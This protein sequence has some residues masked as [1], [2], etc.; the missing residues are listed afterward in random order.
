MVDETG[1]ISASQLRW[2]VP[3][4]AGQAGADFVIDSGMTTTL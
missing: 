4:S 3:T 1:S 2:V